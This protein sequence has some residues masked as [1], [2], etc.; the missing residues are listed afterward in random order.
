MDAIIGVGGPRSE[1]SGGWDLWLPFY[2]VATLALLRYAAG[3]RIRAWT[4]ITAFAA[5]TVLAW[6]VSLF[7]V[8]QA[9]GTAL[10][11]AIAVGAIARR[12]PRPGARSS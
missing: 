3:F 1:I 4:L 8:V 7:G 12:L 9:V 2:M 11:L 5:G 6:S 10:L